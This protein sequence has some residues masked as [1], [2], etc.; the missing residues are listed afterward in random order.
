MD[1]EEIWHSRP[2]QIEQNPRELEY[3]CY[4]LR[5]INPR[6]ILEIGCREGGSLYFWTQFLSDNAQFIAIDSVNYG[7]SKWQNWLREKQKLTF[8]Q[9]GSQD[10]G[11][12]ER[13]KAILEGRNLDFLFIDGNHV[14]PNPKLDYEN[15]S[16]LM[17]KGL[18]AFHDICNPTFSDLGEFWNSLKGEIVNKEGAGTIIEIQSYAK[19]LP[20]STGIHCAGFGVIL[21]E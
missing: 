8:L 20:R 12:I 4:F 19:V 9:G 13:T 18:I 16:P 11:I 14:M 15:Y 21:R 5:E 2:I 1:F 7:A 17:K 10:R 6:T 3:L